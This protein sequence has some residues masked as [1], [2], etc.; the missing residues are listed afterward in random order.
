[1]QP[2]TRML[3]RSVK[4]VIVVNAELSAGLNGSMCTHVRAVDRK[5]ALRE[6]QLSYSRFSVASPYGRFSVQ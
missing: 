2:S 1:M 5:C 4:S 6:Q 3:H